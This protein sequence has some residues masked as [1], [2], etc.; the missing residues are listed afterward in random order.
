[1]VQEFAPLKHIDN[2]LQMGY[3]DTGS[4]GHVPKIERFNRVVKER[5]RGASN[6]LPFKKIP[7]AVVVELLSW[8]VFWLSSFP[9]KK[10]VSK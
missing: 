7:T 2:G 1:M 3:N 5:A 8:A 6:A 4:N 9:S 10:V